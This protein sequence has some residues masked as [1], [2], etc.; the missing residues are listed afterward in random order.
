MNH[1]E[2]GR[3]KAVHER[4]EERSTHGTVVRM[5]AQQPARP[6]TTTS[7]VIDGISHNRCKGLLGH[8]DLD[9]L[10]VVDLTIAVNVCLAEHLIDFLVG[11][12]LAEVCH[13]VAE[14]GRRDEAVA[15][16]VEHTERLLQLLLRISVL[17][18]ARHQRAEL[19][20]VNCAVAVSVD[21]V[22]HVLQLSLG[23]VLAERAHHGAELLGGDGAIAV[24]VEQGEGLLELGDL[25]LSQLLVLRHTCV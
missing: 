10:L 1:V 16:L 6:H 18:L 20:E 15:I 12:L 19:W 4:K 23:R 25:L 3:H 24:L 7:N 17:H 8:H 5:H 22:D 9:E 2:D 14:L 21:L 13:D 11:E